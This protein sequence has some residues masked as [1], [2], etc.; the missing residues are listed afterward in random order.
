VSNISFIFPYAVVS[1][2]A[3]ILEKMLRRFGV[4]SRLLGTALYLL[5]IPAILSLTRSELPSLVV[6][7]FNSAGVVALVASFWWQL[8]WSQV[9]PNK[10][11]QLSVTA[12]TLRVGAR[13]ALSEPVAEA[14]VIFA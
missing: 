2:I 4:R 14:H 12:V 13:N 7:L 11:L 10:R 3:A 8:F 5:I 6:Q 1:I 9:T